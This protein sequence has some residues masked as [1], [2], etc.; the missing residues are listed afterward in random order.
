M[1][2]LAASA[3]V[4]GPWVLLIMLILFL[5]WAYFLVRLVLNKS[6]PTPGDRDVWVRVRPFPWPRIEI[7]VRTPGYERPAEDRSTAEVPPVDVVPI[8]KE[9]GESG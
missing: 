9:A 4:V 6:V 5:V 1:S 3:A 8:R 7:E 2:T